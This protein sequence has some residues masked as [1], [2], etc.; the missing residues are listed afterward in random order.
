[1]P[2]KNLR[3]HRKQNLAVLLLVL[4][5]CALTAVGQNLLSIELNVEATDAARKVLHTTL[6]IPV[7]PGSLTLF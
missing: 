4:Q 7:R 2:K 5:L 6:T 3:N 1:M